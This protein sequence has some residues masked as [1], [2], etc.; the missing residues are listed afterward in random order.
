MPLSRKS[1]QLR[2]SFFFH[3]ED[4]I[5]NELTASS[6]FRS[7]EGFNRVVAAY[8]PFVKFRKINR[9]VISREPIAISSNLQR[10]CRQF[11]L[12]VFTEKRNVDCQVAMPVFR[13][14][15]TELKIIK[16]CTRSFFFGFTIFHRKHRI[17]VNHPHFQRI[18]SSRF[19][20]FNI[21]TIITI[22]RK[23][24]IYSAAT[25][26]H[27]HK[28]SKCCESAFRRFHEILHP[29]KKSYVRQHNKYNT[30]YKKKKKPR[31][32]PEAIFSC[33]DVEQNRLLQ[34]S[35]PSQ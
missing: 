27:I 3:L 31:V 24:A 26:P 14:H 15:F 34:G 23:R 18:N 9:E 21:S 1:I 33:I 29:I 5:V 16:V 19:Y 28:Q 32:L 8:L 13:R 35:R 22:I 10:I 30:I 2:T 20:R 12:F 4:C 25:Q 6:I 11:N 7:K 17:I